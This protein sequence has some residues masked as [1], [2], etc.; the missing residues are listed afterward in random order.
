MITEKETEGMIE[1]RLERGTEIE[2]GIEI[3]RGTEEETEMETEGDVT[4]VSYT[5]RQYIRVHLALGMSE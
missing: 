1:T 5:P 3:E 4:K 2:V